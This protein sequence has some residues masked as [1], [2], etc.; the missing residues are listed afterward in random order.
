LYVDLCTNCLT[1]RA[2]KKTSAA[3]S[4]DMA[5][6]GAVHIAMARKIKNPVI[7]QTCT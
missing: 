3:K 6:A 1:P 7:R 5:R 2:C 4:G